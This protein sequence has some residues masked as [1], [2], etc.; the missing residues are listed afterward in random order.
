MLINWSINC[1]LFDRLLL[2]WLP[3]MH[4]QLCILCEVVKQAGWVRDTDT[5]GGHTERKEKVV[6]RWKKCDWL[7]W[8]GGM[9]QESGASSLVPTSANQATRNMWIISVI[10]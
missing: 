8:E 3:R 2:C 10:M 1:N 6:D 4:A 9:D 5:T 7:K